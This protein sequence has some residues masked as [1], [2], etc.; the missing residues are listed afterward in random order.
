MEEIWRPVKDHAGY[1]VSSLG[2]VRSIDRTIK[3]NYRG[4]EYEYNLRGRILK[5]SLSCFGYLRVRFGK[6]GRFYFIHRLVAEAFIPT[7]KGCS[8]INHKDEVKT[9]NTPENLEWCTMKYNNN[10]N[11]RQERCR[12]TRDKND[13]ERLWLKKSVETKRKNGVY[14]KMWVK[15]LSHRVRKVRQLDMDG[16]LIR[17]WESVTA[18]ANYVNTSTTKISGVC[19]G[20]RKSTRGYKWEYI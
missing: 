14:S 1:E 13:P 10:Y 20:K 17:E 15:F 3:R 2:R 16:N 4:K 19:L 6:M 8:Y 9:N 5:P 7:I 18:A 11:G 12:N